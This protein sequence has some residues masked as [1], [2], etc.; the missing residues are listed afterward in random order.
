MLKK[1]V[2]PIAFLVP[3]FLTEDVVY[4]NCSDEGGDYIQCMLPLDL[5]E[6]G[7]RFD[8]IATVETF[9]WFG[10]G[11]FTKILSQREFKNPHDA[12]GGQCV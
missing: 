5:V 3:R 11:F 12:T 6:P 2:A 1:I 8:G 10:Y 7:E 9:A 4:D